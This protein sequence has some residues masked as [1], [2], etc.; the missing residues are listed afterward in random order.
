ML[1]V[2]CHTLYMILVQKQIQIRSSILL[3]LMLMLMYAYKISYMIALIMLWN[4]IPEAIH[5][6]QSFIQ[7]AGSPGISHFQPTFPPP[8]S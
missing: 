3:M 7:R 2:F 5:P 1:W 4:I 6:L 8:E